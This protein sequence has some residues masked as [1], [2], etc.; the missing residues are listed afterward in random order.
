MSALPIADI[1][2]LRRLVCFIFDALQDRPIQE[3]PQDQG[4][5]TRVEEQERTRTE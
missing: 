2:Y 1:E 4:M 3:N 5:D